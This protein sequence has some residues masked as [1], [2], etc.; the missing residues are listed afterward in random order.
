MSELVGGALAHFINRRSERMGG[1][2]GAA[3]R[4]RGVI[5]AS[6]LMAGGALGGVFGA[7][8]RL[9]P[10]YA[11]DMVKSPFFEDPTASQLIS[12]ALFVGL[13]GYVW[14]ASM[15]ERTPAPK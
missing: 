3:I 14:W 2:P 6:G 4:E 1:E 11:E 7:S 9:F 12:I 13:C 15:R 5:V 10:W 8:L